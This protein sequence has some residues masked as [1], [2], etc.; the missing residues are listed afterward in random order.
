MKEGDEI[1]IAEDE[2]EGTEE[3][4][5]GGLTAATS[6]P[7]GVTRER[8]LL[9]RYYYYLQD[10][11]KSCLV[12]ASDQYSTCKVGILGRHNLLLVVTVTPRDQPVSHI[13]KE[14]PSV[15]PPPPLSLSQC[16]LMLI[17]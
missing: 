16:C 5:F 3:E 2:G 8:K 13:I 7:L 10:K 12:K 4:Q 11:Y 1:R 14:S 17:C 9:P 15:P 6:C